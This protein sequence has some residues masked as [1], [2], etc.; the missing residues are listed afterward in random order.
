MAQ[1]HS[2]THKGANAGHMVDQLDHG[3]HWVWKHWRQWA[4]GLALVL[5]VGGGVTWYR[6]TL[7]T[8]ATEASQA[9]YV[10][11]SNGAEA[12][13]P[14]SEALD[15]FITT[16]GHTLAGQQ[17]RFERAQTALD[18]DDAATVIALLQPLATDPEVLPI[19]QAA[20]WSWMGA[21][22]ET[23]Q[24]WDDAA[25]AYRKIL[26]IQGD[27]VDHARALRNTVRTLRRAGKA[28]EATALLEAPGLYDNA[29]GV[30]QTKDIE[31]LWNA[32]DAA[33]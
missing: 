18:V 29:P 30:K 27:G 26:A 22:H 24:A 32:I 20:A 21:A 5:F 16:F 28:T 33:E 6:H 10:L 2:F 15:A 19:A 9:Y 11:V 13:P 7:Q 25:Q 17:A 1:Y 31:A 4:I 3:L 23:T 8:T 12:T 14:S